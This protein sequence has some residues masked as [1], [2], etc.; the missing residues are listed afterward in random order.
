MVTAFGADCSAADL[1]ARDSIAELPQTVASERTIGV[2]GATSIR[3]R[4]NSASIAQGAQKRL[5]AEDGDKSSIR[6]LC[7]GGACSQ[8]YSTDQV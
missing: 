3:I 2:E 8:P 1:T 4:F 7:F 5:I 6:P